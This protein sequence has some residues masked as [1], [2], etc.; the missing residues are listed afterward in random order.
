MTNLNNHLHC[1]IL[2]FARR[3]Q[4]DRAN[5]NIVAQN[6]ARQKIR[7][8]QFVARKSWR[9]TL[10][11]QIKYWSHKGERRLHS[12]HIFCLTKFCA[13][14]LYSSRYYS[15]TVSLRRTKFLGRHQSSCRKISATKISKSHL[16]SRDDINIRVSKF[17]ATI[18]ETKVC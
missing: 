12:S 3:S 4:F 8:A 10:R 11:D 17:C 16:F 9:K 5:Q 6:F 14:V 18:H 13:T 15:A 2:L 7:R 1:Y